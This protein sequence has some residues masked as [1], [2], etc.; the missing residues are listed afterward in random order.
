MKPLEGLKVVELGMFIS[1]P[2]VARILGDW[3]AEVVKIEALKGD[4]GR[5]ASGQ[6]WL[7]M[8]PDCDPIFSIIQL[9]LPARAS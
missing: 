5:V 6:V 2:G 1:A 3:G 4:N 7:P 8:E 9:F